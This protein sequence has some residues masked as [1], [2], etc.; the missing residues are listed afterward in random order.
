MILRE[1]RRFLVSSPLLGLSGMLVLAL[2]IGASA[3]V[4]ALL[5][6]LFSLA[7]PGMRALG[8]ATITEETEGGGSM[9]IAW[10]RFEEIGAS[11]R[12]SA[13]LAVYSKPVDT[14]L[15]AGGES[16]PLKV[17]GVSSGFFSVFTPRLTAGRDF[18]RAEES[19]AGRHA[20]ILS[21]SL[22]A[23]LFQYPQNA[24]GR[25]VVINGLPYEVVGVAPR[26]FQGMFGDSV[27]AWVPANCVTP[28]IFKASPGDLPYPDVWK[29]VALF[30]GVA[31]SDRVSSTKL[32]ADLTHALPPRT[33]AE[34]PLH[35]SQGLTTDPVRDA[36]LRRWLRL[37]LMLAQV[38]TIVSSLN[39]GLLLLA[40][41]PRYVEE[42]RLK[43]ALGA[44]S[45]RLLAE[46][47]MGPAAMVGAGLLAAGFFM[48]VGLTSLAR[49]PG[50]YGQL[51]QGSW[52]AAFL[53]LGV[54]VPFA[55]GLT[56][57]IALLPALGLLRDD[58]A[59]RM[60]YAAT[61][62]RRTGFLLQV[63]V[64]LQI[65]F[66]IGAWILAGMVV[67]A[68]TSLMRQNLGYDLNHLTVVSIGPGSGGVTYTFGPHRSF[69]T[70]W[71][72]ASVL[73][74]VAALPGVRSAGFVSY[75]PFGTGM[76]TLSLQRIGDASAA[77]RTVSEMMLTPGS[78]R[79]MGTRIIR[80]RDFSSHNLTGDLNEILINATL[81]R[82]LWPNGDAVNSTVSLTHPA[83]SGIPSY[84]FPVTIIGVV[85]DM[86]ISGFTESPEPTVF[87][88]F[89]GGI[90]TPQLIVNGSE[91]I[92]SLQDVVARQV[93]ALM[94]GLVVNST[95]R[96]R[97]RARAA[98][99]PEERRAYLALASAS[100]MAVI[101]GI[102]LYGALVYYVGTR[103]RE[104]AVRVCLG[105]P[106]W[107][108]RKIILVR[109]ALCA[110]SAAILSL[111]LWPIVA[112]LSSNDYLGR[113]SWS[114]G[115]AALIALACVLVSVCVS[116]IPASAAASV[117]PSD[118]LKEQ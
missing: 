107:A 54:Q 58:G 16:R 32:V 111:P 67:S 19:Q 2:G 94:P 87:L 65:A 110:I 30:Y 24:L 48:V 20:A 47:M 28:L 43:K 101:A 64:T 93:P 96:V 66:C 80:G 17:A 41:T 44:G 14:A 29:E 11:S 26:G 34:A 8:Y 113:I 5:L 99:W 31:A 46:L 103:R 59:P 114:P 68:V 21:N 108:I 56:L 33:G 22:A 118:V 84:N 42:V 79:T 12:Q 102:G 9:R 13:A 81:A 75:A 49:M 97:D 92:H 115:R 106:P 15:Q 62:T 50:F 55:C 83:N 38:A 61:A 69:P 3:L 60:G 45:S 27:E 85:E 25:S 7:Y 39:Y 77:A 91:S 53:A 40:R 89:Q 23:E 51:G 86:R 36:Q 6:T 117:S 57:V 74:Q 18:S 95:Y 72:V 37:G 78:F 35:V 109:A 70:A 10:R 98:L 105:A 73:E 76:G 82:E 88:A 63:P 4:L 71:A 52:H 100:A 116:L 90:Y 112:R 1:V 104:L